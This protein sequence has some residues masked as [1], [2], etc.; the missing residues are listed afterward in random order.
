[1]FED[2]ASAPRAAI[3]RQRRDGG[4]IESRPEPHRKSVKHK[5][6]IT[7]RYAKLIGTGYA[8]KK[9]RVEYC[10][11]CTRAGRPALQRIDGEIIDTRGYDPEN[12]YHYKRRKGNGREKTERRGAPGI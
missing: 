6:C 4:I 11:Y 12:C 8:P 3:S 5:Q 10:D 7:C 9:S 2:R 1:M